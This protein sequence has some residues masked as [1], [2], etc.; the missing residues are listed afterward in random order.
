MNEAIANGGNIDYLT[1]LQERLGGKV[2]ETLLRDLIPKI[3]K[4]EL[5]SLSEN[6]LDREYKEKIG[7]IFDSFSPKF[8]AEAAIWDK[9]Y[10]NEWLDGEEP[11]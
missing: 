5:A 11:T 4:G 2:S 3:S 8:A 7:L 10:L 1:D 6:I 9:S